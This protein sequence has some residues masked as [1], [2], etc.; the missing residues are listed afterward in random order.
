M[1]RNPISYFKTSLMQTLNSSLND[2]Q[3][4]VVYPIDVQ[5][6]IDEVYKRLQAPNNSVNINYNTGNLVEEN[7]SL[8]KLV[9]KLAS[10]NEAISNLKQLNKNNTPPNSISKIR[11][12]GDKEISMLKKIVDESMKD[13]NINKN[14]VISF[15]QSETQTEDLNK[16]NNSDK[17]RK[18]NVI[19]EEKVKN[20]TVLKDEKPNMEFDYDKVIKDLKNNNKN[21]REIGES[22]NST[23]TKMGLDKNTVNSLSKSWELGKNSTKEILQKINNFTADD[24]LSKSNKSERVKDINDLSNNLV[25][26]KIDNSK[27]NKVNN[28]QSILHNSVNY[29]KND[30]VSKEVNILTSPKMKES[31]SSNASKLKQFMK[32]NREKLRKKRLEESKKINETKFEETQNILIDSIASTQKPN[33]ISTNINQSNLN[34]EKSDEIDNSKVDDEENVNGPII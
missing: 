13:P 6:K 28:K 10:A 25:K 27:I 32:E 11:E 26:S 16:S 34:I 21:L 14:S 19:N 29:I 2:S 20:I 9:R 22:L 5:K 24:I 12:I 31:I 15:K 3:N 23:I 1:P 17:I 8:K 30:T 33:L 18:D 4:S 7:S